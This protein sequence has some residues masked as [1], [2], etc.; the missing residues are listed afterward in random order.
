MGTTLW[1]RIADFILNNR[2][3]LIIGIAL[4]TLFMALQ[5][6]KLEMS[7]RLEKIVPPTNPQYIA[8]EKFIDQ[9][10][11]DGNVMVI[12]VQ[13]EDFFKTDFFNAWYQFGNDLK[14]IDNVNQVLSV[15]HSFYL[16][17]DTD[18]K[19]FELKALV[20]EEV[21]NQSDLDSL[22]KKF[23]AL[24]FYEGLLYNS[25]SNVSLMA[26]TIDK[27]VLDSEDRMT[28]VN[29]IM[30][31]SKKFESDSGKELHYSGLPFIR[32]FR[33][34][35]VSKELGRFLLLALLA[36][37]I[38]LFVLFRSFSSVFYP[39]LVVI[40]GVIWTVGSIV[41]LGYEVNVLTGIVPTLI[42][43]I[44]IPNCIYLLNKYHTEFKR[45]GNQREALKNM[46]EMVG[47]VTFYANLTTAIG[48]GVFAFMKSAILKEF[49][50][51]AGLNI[52]ATFFISIIVIPVIY[53]Y[54][55]AP[56]HKHIGHQ[57]RSMF[58]GVLNFLVQFTSKR[59]MLIQIGAVLLFGV[60]TIGLLKLES[61]G[62]LLDGI[63]HESKEYQDLKFLEKNFNGVLPLEI[64][65]DTKK[66]GGAIRLS[67]LK[68]INRVQKMI[69]EIEYFSEPIS[70]VDGVKLANQAFY[71]NHPDFFQLPSKLESSF[72]F[73]YIKNTG[74]GSEDLL[75]KFTDD[76]QRV[77]RMSVRMADVG[78]EKFPL[79]L[80]E[81]KPKVNAILDTSKFEVTYTGTTPIALEGFN[82]L[83]R[84][85]TNSVL[86]AIALI[87]LIIIYL[88]RSLKMLLVAVLPNALP[89]VCTAS[90]M[91]FNNINLNPSTVI[92]FS[93]AFGISIDF[94]LHYIAKYRQ[95]L[96]ANGGHVK[97]AVFNS[98]RETG[99]SMIYT[100]II[101]FF[102]FIVFMLSSFEGTYF[103]G[104]LTSITIVA[105]CLT[106]LILLPAILN[107]FKGFF[108]PSWSKIKDK[109]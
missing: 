9:Y 95:A 85:L 25:E 91:G 90:I 98:V 78:S 55:G 24:T 22:A 45:H 10:G 36:T 23:Q 83:I 14:K 84:G 17:K 99:F 109:K 93:I 34:G 31:R 44:G 92:I 104:L 11:E 35:V 19:K 30:E 82:Y 4:I 80:E 50:T 56:K 72:I 40:I 64:L 76:E 106:N 52:A 49:G 101:L 8:Y 70:L 67:N 62:F 81:L 75:G 15:P 68:K 74:K 103:L 51:V 29:N 66:K 79:L 42:V 77:V 88:F 58:N 1:A 73:N 54:R 38:I 41:L 46:I 21:R 37:A 7:Y 97:S 13:N 20:E 96:M 2:L 12:G 63:Q 71:N 6:P 61:K 89:L 3:I 33:V 69:G 39:L 48:M 94:T 27:S 105:A 87:S 108:K 18:E 100:A 32:S 5:I 16:E 86:L 102:G 60:A 26:V 43:V 65:V 59:S 57:D 107:G 47:Q 28:V 53:S